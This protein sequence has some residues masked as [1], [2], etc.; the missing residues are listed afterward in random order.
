M[1]IS[2]FQKC[3]FEFLGTMILILMGDGVCANVSLNKSKA[4]GA[5]DPSVVLSALKD[6]SVEFSL[7]AWVKSA[8]YWTV[9]HKINE[10]IY[11]TLPGK[12]IEFPFPQIDVHLSKN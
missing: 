5:G 9:Y 8:D 11:T 7:K 4:K 1:E 3:V 12:G 2:L 6:S 10:A